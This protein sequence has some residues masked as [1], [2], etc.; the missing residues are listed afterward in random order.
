MKNQNEEIW[1]W[2]KDGF[3]TK[4]HKTPE[5]PPFTVEY[6]GEKRSD[7]DLTPQ[8]RYEVISIEKDWFRL[9]DDMGSDDEEPP[10]YLYP[11]EFFEIIH[12]KP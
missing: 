9:I 5:K 8:K 4:T 7:I 12:N 1:L 11:P 2:P 10:G 3:S 6:I